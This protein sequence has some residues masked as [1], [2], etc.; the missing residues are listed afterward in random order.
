MKL[1]QSDGHLRAEALRAL[2][3]NHPLEELERLE[4]AEHL[5]FCDL[6]LQ[7]Y[8]QALTEYALLTPAHSCRETIWHWIRSRTLRILS[9]RYATAAA[10]V[11]IALTLLWAEIP[12]PQAITAEGPRL[13]EQIQDWPERWSDSIGAMMEHFI[14]FLDQKV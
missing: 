4:I 10:A 14:L 13:V 5:A 6:C 11:A 12:L 8:T 1:F 2:A 9:S 3:Q 7:R